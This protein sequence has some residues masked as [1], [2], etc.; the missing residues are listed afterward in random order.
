MPQQSRMFKICC[1]LNEVPC[2]TFDVR[3]TV[4]CS[5]GCGVCVVGRGGGNFCIYFMGILNSIW[6]NNKD[7]GFTAAYEFDTH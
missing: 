4:L 3:F 5:G 1:K 2:L 7:V 6:L